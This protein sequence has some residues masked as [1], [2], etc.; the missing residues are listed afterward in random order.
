MI[1]PP[2]EDFYQTRQRIEPIGLAYLAASLREKGFSPLI[3][4]CQANSKKYT[5]NYPSAFQYLKDFYVPENLSPFKLF[6]HFYHFGL[7]FKEIEE[8]IR[9]SG[10]NIFGISSMFSTY[11]NE[12]LKVAEII[13]K[14][15]SRNIVIMGGVHASSN[16]LDILKSPYVDFVIIGEGEESLPI[17]LENLKKGDF[18]KIA[19][20]DG[21]GYKENRNIKINPKQKWIKNLDTI[22]FPA[23]DLFKEKAY[24]IGKKLSTKILTSRGCPCLCSFCSVKLGMGNDF[25]KRSPENILEE[26][27]FCREKFGIEAFDF[28]DDNLGLDREVFER[29]LDLIIENFGERNLRLYAMNGILPAV[30][31]KPILDKMKKAGFENINLTLASRNEGVRSILGRPDSLED[32]LK[33]LNLACETG[34]KVTG[35]I[36]LGVPGQTI[37]GMVDDLIF[38][39]GKPCLIGPSIF[40]PVI[41]TPLFEEYS[42]K[43][44]FDR[45]DFLRLRSPAFPIETEDFTRADIFTL[46][47]LARLL[48]FIKSTT[49]PQCKIDPDHIVPGFKENYQFSS[50]KKLKENEIGL[51][52]LKL[53][54]KERD[55]F[56]ARLIKKTHQKFYYEI[57]K[58][59]CSRRV[60]DKFLEKYKKV[61]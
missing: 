20:I 22:P 54:F 25:R 55:F 27:R 46:F 41:G 47:Y 24:S 45:N 5:I 52:L 1:Q 26:M 8:E 12:A 23:R 14:I 49:G 4:D 29:L 57:F 21:I 60:I 48:N 3:L 53:F 11:Y 31:S 61:R 36:F 58:E 37:Q 15:N 51:L 13:K 56:G 28:E 16:S 18:S 9:K 44:L 2:V 19:E 6:G 42:K 35:Y 7:S 30:L 32:F 17:L 59:R 33:A 34:I 50:D 39:T 38:L 40:Y 10:V 43:G